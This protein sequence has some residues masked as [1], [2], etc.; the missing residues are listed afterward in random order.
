VKRAFGGQAKLIEA[1]IFRVNLQVVDYS[2]F[3]G[4]GSL[5]IFDARASAESAEAQSISH[6]D[7]NR[8][9]RQLN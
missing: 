2:L 9:S 8:L 1:P 5:A 7:H 3:L 4:R 6:R